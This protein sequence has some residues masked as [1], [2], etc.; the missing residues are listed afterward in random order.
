MRRDIPIVQK[1]S[2]AFALWKRESGAGRKGPA[3]LFMSAANLSA[4]R[5]VTAG[6]MT[7]RNS[8]YLE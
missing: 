1:R 2:L 8:T 6:M 5:K 4:A 7:A 3:W